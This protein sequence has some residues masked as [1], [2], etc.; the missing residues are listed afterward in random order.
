MKS[1]GWS[2]LSR[3]EQLEFM[4]REGKVIRRPHDFSR[5]ALHWSYCGQC[6]LVALKNEATRLAMKAPCE[7]EGEK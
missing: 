6:G 7:T 3:D 2:V 4:S 1:S 5:R